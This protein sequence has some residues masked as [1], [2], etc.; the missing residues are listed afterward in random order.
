M[1]NVKHNQILPLVLIIIDLGAALVYLNDGNLRKFV[2]WVAA[3]ALT[4]VV[5]F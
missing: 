2:Y 3:A 5:T 4:T 1:F